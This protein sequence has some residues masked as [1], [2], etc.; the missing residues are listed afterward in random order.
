[1]PQCTDRRLCDAA[2]TGDIA[3]IDHLLR[4]PDVVSVSD[5][6][7]ALMHAAHRGHVRAV[8]LLLPHANPLARTSEALWR[9]ARY[10][11]MQCIDV[12]VAVSSPEQWESWQW[13]DLPAAGQDR[14][15]RALRRLGRSTG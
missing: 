4:E 13:T 9:A 6:D 2:W 8:L 14:V 3:A 1:M 7:T 15:R 5:P 11:R 12:L 10:R